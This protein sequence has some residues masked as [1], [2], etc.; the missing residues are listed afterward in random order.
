M[1]Y[2][3]WAPLW[4]NETSF[5]NLLGWIDEH[6]DAVDEISLFDD[7]VH[8][9]GRPEDEEREMVRQITDRIGRLREGREI[10]VGINV[11]VTLGHGLHRGLR[12]SSLEPMVESDGAPGGGYCWSSPQLMGYVKTHYRRMA[13][14]G[15]DFIWVD[16]DFRPAKHGVKYPCFCDRCIGL[17][18]DSLSRDDLV[19]ALNRPD[20]GELR[21]RWSDFCADR[22]NAIC[23]AIEE[24]VHTVSPK[25]ELGLMTVG[26]GVST[27]A[28]YPISRFMETLKAVKG[29][30][31][32]GFYTDDRP[33]NLVTKA[34]ET[35]RQVR[36]YPEGVTDIQYELENFPYVTLDKSV[37]T[38]MNE[39]TASIAMGCN[40]IAFNAVYERALSFE[41]YRPLAFAVAAECLLWRRYLEFTGGVESIPLA[42]FRAVDC[43]DLMARRMVDADAGSEW[44]L[45]GPDDDINVPLGLAAMGIPL[46]VESEGSCGT[47]LAGR[48]AEG[49]DDSELEEILSG[50]VYMDTRTLEVLHRRGFGEATGVRMGEFHPHCVEMLT[51]HEL[52]GAD[53]GE[54]RRKFPGP[55]GCSIL[56]PLSDVVSVLAEV[57]DEA[58]G[59]ILG[60]SLTLF[61]N[62]L[63]GRVAVASYSPF[64]HLGRRAKQTQVIDLFRHL[65]K[66]RMPVLIRGN[67]RVWPIVRSGR[68]LTAVMLFNCSFDQICNLQVEFCLSDDE[69]PPAGRVELTA[70]RESRIDSVSLEFDDSGAVTIPVL[71]PWNYVLLLRDMS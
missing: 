4:R 26:Y 70:C 7:F 60:P 18:D 23:S 61:E 21:R 54:G 43:P 69:A 37:R 30:P 1:A 3:I 51:G 71:D 14:T 32:H 16:D 66:N 64:S 52:N 58:S 38:V 65:S 22:M 9:I 41:E 28:G 49:L 15:P 11:L 19:T 25:I 53:A 44:F 63:G 55:N 35:A 57:A 68:N 2:R 6:R 39:C 50:G 62:N 67:H 27:Y 24:A 31:G 47:V 36:D 33:W 40:G 34:F 46:T 8:Q 56:E 48:I 29:R 13:E 45:E 20:G 12:E 42:G 5:R 17:F 10:D 59:R